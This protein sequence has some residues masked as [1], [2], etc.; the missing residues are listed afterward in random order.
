VPASSESSH[1]RSTDCLA[2]NMKVS[3]S[4]VTM[5]KFSSICISGRAGHLNF[6]A[7]FKENIHIL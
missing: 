2:L 6:N 5:V 7:F 3:V 1:P 4:Y